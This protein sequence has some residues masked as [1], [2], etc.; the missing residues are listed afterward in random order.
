MNIDQLPTA[1]KQST[2][3]VMDYLMILRKRKWIVLLVFLTIVTTATVKVYLRQPIYAGVAKILIDS[4]D[5]K[6]L[7]FE[8][9]FYSYDGFEL[10]TQYRIL[11]S[12]SLSKATFEKLGL[13]KDEEFADSEDPVGSFHS[14]FSIEPVRNSRIVLVKAMHPDPKKAALYAN[15]F[16]QVYIDKNLERR[17]GAARYAVDWLTKQ[18]AT[19]REKVEKSELALQNYVAA[20]QILHMPNIDEGGAKQG[21]IQQ[22][23]SEKV[24]LE[25]ELSELS[26]RYKEKHPKMI[27]LKSVLAAVDERL[28]SEIQIVFDLNRKA[29]K[30]GILKREVE[31]NRQLYET[32]LEKSKEQNLFEN[33]TENNISIIDSA[34]IPKY[35]VYP[36][37]RRSV[38]LGCFM[39]ILLGCA[40]A[41][42]LEALDNTVK[43]VEDAQTLTG[44]PLL[45][46]VPDHSRLKK[47]KLGELDLACFLDSKS[48]FAESYRFI[49]TGIFFSSVDNPARVILLTSSS[50]KEGKTTDASNL[51]ITLAANGEK[52]LLIDAD[53]RNPRIHKIFKLKDS[54]VGLSNV[55]T[56]GTG[57]NDAIRETQVPNLFVL[58]AG[59]HPPNPAELLESQKMKDFLTWAS[60]N[61]KKVIIDTPP[62]MAVAD[63]I[64]LSAVVDGVIFV[65][66]SGVTH[67]KQVIQALNKLS[68]TQVK[69]FGIVLN[70]VRA[71]TDNYYYPYYYRYYGERQRKDELKT[72]VR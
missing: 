17:L 49:R 25:T 57:V 27:R 19:V 21:V 59:Q 14:L 53:L 24:K 52:V 5:E 66:R 46:C 72:V 4:A 40:L 70:R 43:G 9:A 6:V 54:D 35:A 36:N 34:E 47:I 11:S 60:N 42:F 69:I 7:S 16:S 48:P 8:Q 22:L 10:D 65:I 71:S 3:G 30:Y 45:G 67:R 33:L 23:E 37:K 13:S 61:F 32:I 51:A 1:Q 15:T 41:F 56:G 44:L 63:P 26:K 18:L 29:T 58:P 38:M 50:P 39:G 62:V 55:L 2:R 68:E 64:I 28:K 12:R 31:S 20:N